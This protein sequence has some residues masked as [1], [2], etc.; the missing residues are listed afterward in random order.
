VA[1]P[2]EAAATAGWE[3]R[4]GWAG[5]GVNEEGRRASSQGVER[6]QRHCFEGGAVAEKERQE[7]REPR[8]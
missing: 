1:A 3:A 2:Q 4:E 7:R 5:S 6:A 8:A